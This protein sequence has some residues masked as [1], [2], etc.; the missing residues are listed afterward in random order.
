VIDCPSL[1]EYARTL[2]NVVFAQNN[3]YTCSETGLLEIKKG[4]EQNQLNR[5]IVAACT[6]RTHEPLF[7][8]TCAEKGVN[9][10][11][12][13]FVNIREQVSW[14]HQKEPEKAYDKA[15][16]LV[17]M[18]VAR[19]ARLEPLD[20]I[21]IDVTPSTA[22]IGGGI[23]GMTAALSLANQGYHVK[24]IEKTNKLGGLLNNLHRLYPHNTDPAQILSI[25]EKITNH[26]N[27]EIFLSTL[28]EKVEGF[29]GNFE[30]TCHQK[31][32]ENHDLNT[33]EVGTIIVATGAQVLHSPERYPTNGQNII[34]QLELEQKL[35]NNVV[36]G[37]R[38]IM[39]QCA[40]TR[41]PERP[42]CSSIC[43]MTALKNAKLLK[44][45]Y[46]DIDV[47]ILNR[48]IHLTGTYQETYYRDVRENGVVF[49]RYDPDHPPV[50]EENHVRLYNPSFKVDLQ[51]PYDL[52]VLA[53]PLIPQDGMKVI[54]QMLKV[55][56]EDNG[57][58]LEAHVKL[59][60]VDF[61]NDGIFVCGA[62]KWPCNVSEAIAQGLAASARV[63]RIIS[64]P[65][66]TVEGAIAEIDNSKC[67]GCEICI[68]LCPYKAIFKDEEEKVVV[69]K[70]LCKGC[71]VCGSSCPKTAIKIKHFTNE[72]ILSQVEA[73]MS[74]N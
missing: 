63:S 71:G 17:R 19:A 51:I 47:T 58:F 34:S 40:G 43:C 72:Q 12:F 13:E 44:M 30:I 53:T 4:I 67:I 16:D 18:G 10:Y 50:I 20:K 14:V 15:K 28:I 54:A 62:A 42:Y 38:I 46:P 11:Y 23:A 64:K 9:P 32:N 59:R 33:F 55:P 24:L 37:K 60:P 66:V 70:V 8:S 25:I 65:Q 48:D 1:T 5:V 26:S 73:L 68:D 57:F 35:R 45:A 36:N 31:Q 69:R 29:V 74:D 7:R 3:L 61:S 52:V 39:I 49:M 41:V 6:P 21:K 27:I 2:P 22:I 56:I